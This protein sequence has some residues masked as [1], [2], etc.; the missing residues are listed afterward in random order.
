VRE[1]ECVCVRVMAR[2]LQFQFGEVFHAAL[3]LGAVVALSLPACCDD[4]AAS[5]RA[6]QSLN[7]ATPSFGSSSTGSSAGS[8]SSSQPGIASKTSSS[9]SRAASLSLD[10]SSQSNGRTPDYQD[11][12]ELLKS[13][14]ESLTS[15]QGTIN[16]PTVE[17]LI[18]A[19]AVAGWDPV[20]R[21]MQ[22]KP[23]VKPTDTAAPKPKKVTVVTNVNVMQDN[24]PIINKMTS[25]D[26]L[27]L[28]EQ[29]AKDQ[30]EA[31][32]KQVDSARVDARR[33]QE[34]KF[35]AQTKEEAFKVNRGEQSQS[36][37]E[38]N[39]KAA[40]ESQSKYNARITLEESTK[41]QQYSFAANHLKAIV[42]QNENAF[43]QQK[44][45]DAAQ[46]APPPLLAGSTRP[47][48]PRFREVHRNSAAAR[49]IQRG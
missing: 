46:P 7:K 16:V 47:M 35:F 19:G 24:M 2:R 41:Q 17:K 26:L 22:T 11:Q 4:S 12:R 21:H 5:L 3:L 49:R 13:I 23:G 40:S 28:Q 20:G 1:C 33:E 9:K 32:M 8:L 39:M 45:K 18:H 15:E 10:K 38:A 44:L 31:R 29:R 27:A 37:A 48:P 34:S 25:H 36:F 14:V 42:T 30:Q 6:S 43:A